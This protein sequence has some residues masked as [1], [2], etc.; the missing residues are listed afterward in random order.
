MQL[1][2]R[3]MMN[4]AVF[5]LLILSYSALASPQFK[6]PVISSLT[7]IRCHEDSLNSEKAR[8]RLKWATDHNILPMRTIKKWM[9]TFDENME[10]ILDPL[11]YYPLFG[12]WD[13]NPDNSRI[14]KTGTHHLVE[15]LNFH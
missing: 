1:L 13:E 2:S 14:W 6:R 12:T 9:Y 11:P 8:R 4:T 7:A 3:A 10:I 5:G 15:C